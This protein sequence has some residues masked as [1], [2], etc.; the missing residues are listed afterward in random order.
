[1]LPFRLWRLRAFERLLAT[2]RSVAGAV[3]QATV[4]GERGEEAAL[5]YLRRAGYVV[6]AQ[7][8]RTA[9]TRGDVDLIAWEGDTLC[10]VEVKTRAAGQIVS[11]EA[12]VDEEKRRN[13]RRMARNYVKL[14][15]PTAESVRFDVVS[16]TP[17]RGSSVRRRRDLSDE[18]MLFRGAFG[19]E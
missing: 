2:L 17:E 13:M 5:F 19:W 16:V 12:A 10:F 6:V 8:W 14:V 3:E 4:N 9:K 11:A 18:V 1:M 15:D 7:R